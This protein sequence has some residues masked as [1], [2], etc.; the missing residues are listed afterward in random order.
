M[1]L[2]LINGRM[3]FTTAVTYI[4]AALMVIFLTQP[5]HEYAHAKVADIL[6]DKTARFS[7]RLTVNPFAHIDYFGAFGGANCGIFGLSG[8][9]SAD[10]CPKSKSRTDCIGFYKR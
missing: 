9:C 4:V 2:D 8:I 1:L 7:G 6:G 5:F 3:N 10:T